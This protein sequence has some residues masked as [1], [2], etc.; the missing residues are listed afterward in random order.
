M[1]RAVR[2]RRRNR[3]GHPKREDDAPRSHVPRTLPLREN[4]PRQ[5]LADADDRRARTDRELGRAAP[6]RM[7]PP[8]LRRA[9]PLG[10]DQHVPSRPQVRRG[11]LRQARV[12]RQRGRADD[13]RQERVAP[14]RVLGDVERARQ[15]R[16]DQHHVD[17]RRM[18]RD[19]DR[20]AH[21]LRGGPVGDVEDEV[22]SAR[23][24]GMRDDLEPVSDKGR[25]K[26]LPDAAARTGYDDFPAHGTYFLDLRCV[27][28]W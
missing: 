15:E 9:R 21:G 12:V 20:A 2:D 25:G 7:L 13:R 3:R 6:E 23:T 8:A 26:R 28:T 11:G 18:V 10:E 22:G 4:P 5:R 24:D 27:L 16:D 17:E 1:R 14:E 19:D